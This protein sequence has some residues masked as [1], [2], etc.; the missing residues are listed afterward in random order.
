MLIKKYGARFNKGLKII[1]LRDILLLS[2][3]LVAVVFTA[4]QL[5]DAEY[6]NLWKT[7]RTL[8]SVYGMMSRMDLHFRGAIQVFFE[9]FMLSNSLMYSELWSDRLSPQEASFRLKE[10]Q[11]TY[12][13]TVIVLGSNRIYTYLINDISLKKLDLANAITDFQMN[14]YLADMSEDLRDK[15]LKTRLKIKTFDSI[16]N[17]P[18]SEERVSGITF[19]GTFKVAL[20]IFERNLRVLQPFLTQ[21]RPP[22]NAPKDVLKEEFL[23]F[24]PT[25][26]AILR[27]SFSGSLDFHTET[28]KT[29]KDLMVITQPKKTSTM[30]LIYDG[31]FFFLYL[32]FLAASYYLFNEIKLWLF[33][34]LSQYKNLRK[35]EALIHKILLSHRVWFIQKYRL[36]EPMMINNYMKVTYS[37]VNHEA[38]QLLQ[39]NKDQASQHNPKRVNKIRH[40]IIF[41]SFITM[42]LMTVLSFSL[43]I[44]YMV[45]QFKNNGSFSTGH[46]RIVFY[47]D[48][49]QNMADAY[50][51][52]LVHIMYLSVG[53]Y[54]Q[55]SGQDPGPYVVEMQLR[56]PPTRS[57]I[58][59]FIDQRFRLQEFFGGEE[60]REI[61]KMLFDN[62]CNFLDQSRSTYVA[63]L[64]ICNLNAYA[65][66][67]YVS[68]LYHT[69]DMLQEI[70]DLMP[71][72]PD[73]IAQS[74]S[75]WL[76]FPINSYIYD[77][78]KFSFRIT[79]RIITQAVFDKILS[80]GEQAITRE[81]DKLESLIRVLNRIIPPIVIVLYVI[82]F[83]VSALYNL[84]K[85]LRMCA[86]SLFNM[87][88]EIMVQNKTIY[89]KFNETYSMKY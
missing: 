45:I 69:R 50:H 71:E 78:P 84:K 51:Y 3:Y 24:I 16:T 33:D 7:S 18:V 77:P 59:Y 30:I 86:E 52:Y 82:A 15:V 32:L 62:S 83:A 22:Y 61:D 25:R 64:R 57:L 65:T 87:L 9:R 56:R 81:L 76:L 70:R 60:G 19:L 40:N 28:L 11:T 39:A 14:E 2:F 36:D 27:N 42:W 46:E 74:E 54:I 34:L 35:E 20:E 4:F 67:G 68:F 8:F 80:A 73:F 72:Y 44:Y 26:F 47:T 21:R 66:K 31:L 49:Y 89:K 37:P 6:F 1:N 5:L 55:V 17:K 85:D 75:E 10:S 38:V 58:K 53:N 79:S 13:N 41:R 29:I 63:D 12:D 48:T 43:A 23:D 88:P